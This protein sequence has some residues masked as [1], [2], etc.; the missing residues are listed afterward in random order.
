M[1]VD[2]LRATVHGPVLQRTDPGFAEELQGQNLYIQHTPELVVGASCTSDV[3]AAVRYAAEHHLHVSVLVTGHEAQQPITAGVVI[4][5]QR[6]DTVSIDAT[7][8]IATVAG[9]ARAGEVAEAA[10]RF[11][12]A[13]I[14]GAATTVG[15][16][17]LVLGGGLGPLARSHGYCS[18]YVNQFTV[19]VPTGEIVTANNDENPEL[20]WALRG[21]KAG[22]GVVVETRIRLVDLAS[23]YGGSV[24][25]AQNDIDTVLRGWVA[26][27]RTA[28]EEVTTS[29]AL[30]HFPPAPELPE[31]MRGQTFLMLRF[32]Y[33][34]P[35]QEG[36]RLA[37]PLLALAEPAF[38]EFGELPAEQLGTMH[39]DP[40]EP[41][42]SWTDG[43]L[44]NALDDSFATTLLDTVGDGRQAP[45]MVIELRHLG[46]ATHRDVPEE[47][48]VSGRSAEYS[49]YVVG[50][51]NPDLF[52]TTLPDAL[53]HL[54]SDINPY[55]APETFINWW[56]G[57]NLENFAKSWPPQTHTRL[58]ELR[59]EW[60]PDG[61][62]TY[63]A[64]TA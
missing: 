51:P 52:E 58:C 54:L 60:D 62:F 42:M 61:I 3:Q 29:V 11:G 16:T 26:W 59:T 24:A 23:F 33:P 37:A 7:A 41:I 19:V 5:L 30:M 38:G 53:D 2:E 10:A 45:F 22:F 44:L 40:T 46:G 28:P 27:T 64:K 17:G 48:A 32:A 21:G 6:L 14:A 43:T 34:G 9:G 20:F 12:L 57:R 25:F 15:L 4:T 8:R 56:S 1:T 50:V 47:S 63:P 36:Q 39:D 13:P 55:L 35:A 18:D 49:L 31:T